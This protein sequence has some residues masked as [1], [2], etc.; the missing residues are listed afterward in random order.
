[1]DVYGRDDYSIFDNVVEKS[2]PC[3]IPSLTVSQIEKWRKAFNYAAYN[4]CIARLL[5]DND[6]HIFVVY[7]PQE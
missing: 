3:Y 2:L 6:I 5:D 1:M 7:E 4:G